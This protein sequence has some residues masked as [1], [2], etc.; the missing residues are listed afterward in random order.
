MLLAVADGCE[1]H[2][3]KPFSLL[4]V[5][6]RCRVLRSQWCQSGVNWSHSHLKIHALVEEA[7]RDQPHKR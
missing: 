7:Q 3:A 2:V 5:A 1:T 4:T 6:H